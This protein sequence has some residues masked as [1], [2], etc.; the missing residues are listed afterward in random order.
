MTN[1]HEI[2][3]NYVLLRCN[4]ETD[5]IPGDAVSVATVAGVRIVT[6]CGMG[7][8]HFDKLA[9]GNLPFRA[10][11]SCLEP[12]EEQRTLRQVE[13]GESH[14]ICDYRLLIQ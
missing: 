10:A 8:E 4:D 3:V 6:L 14:S 7:S 9:G 11:L 12:L 13:R 2:E 1:Q 5:H